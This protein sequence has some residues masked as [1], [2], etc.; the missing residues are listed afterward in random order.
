[1]LAS[2]KN[3]VSLQRLGIGF[4]TVKNPK[5]QAGHVTKLGVAK[6]ILR[7]YSDRITLA[8]MFQLFTRLIEDAFSADH[9]FLDYF[10]CKYL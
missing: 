7:L 10:Y 4:R 8:L 2:M 5:L 9:M 6:R 3:E 1:M